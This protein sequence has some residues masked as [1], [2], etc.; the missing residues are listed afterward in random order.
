MVQSFSK[1]IYTKSRHQITIL[2]ML[3]ATGVGYTELATVHP[4]TALCGYIAGDDVTLVVGSSF[5]GYGR[6][7]TTP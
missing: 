3:K 6:Y 1:D 7:S 2:P 4:A 5:K